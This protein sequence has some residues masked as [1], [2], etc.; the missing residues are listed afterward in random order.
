MKN[1]QDDKS[2]RQIS[3]KIPALP[4]LSALLVLEVALTIGLITSGLFIFNIL[5]GFVALL[6]GCLLVAMII[7]NLQPKLADAL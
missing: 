6:I 4:L 5:G 7:K 3:R 1:P 2:R